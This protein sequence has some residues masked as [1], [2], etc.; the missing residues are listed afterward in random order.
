MFSRID[1]VSIAVSDYDRAHDFFS[2][3]LGATP[4]VG[5]EDPRLGYF[6]RIFALGDLTRLELIKPIGEE[7]FLKGF[8]ADK[9]GGVHHITL[10]TPDIQQARQRLEENNIPFFGYNDSREAWKEL[11]I[12]PRDAFGVL[13]Q[14]A[15]F[16]PD[17]YIPEQLKFPKPGKRWSIEKR[18]TEYE[19]ALAHPG[20]G[21]AHFSLNREELKELI[22]DLEDVI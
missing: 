19:L 15:Q 4:S 9:D 5:A 10:E 13:I 22:R 11:F 14:I 12:H 2:G 17:D 3:I 1:H 16:D 18:G 7:S 21:K 20:G 8:L 6:W